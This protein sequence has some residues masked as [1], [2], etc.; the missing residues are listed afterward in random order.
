[1]KALVVH[2]LFCVLGVCVG[3]CLG[4]ALLHLTG[5][6]DWNERKAR[7]WQERRRIKRDGRR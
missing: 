5:F 4:V 3:A 6:Y 1:M 2:S 7:E